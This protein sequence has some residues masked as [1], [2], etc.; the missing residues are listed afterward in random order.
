MQRT[1]YRINYENFLTTRP[2]NVKFKRCK[3][4]IPE[5]W[6]TKL[7]IEKASFSEILNIRNL[8]TKSNISNRIVSCFAYDSELETIWRNPFSKLKTLRQTLAVLTP[9]FSVTPSM[10]KAQIINS[11]F[12]N[13]WMG[14]FYQQYSIDVIPTVSWAEPW[15][16][17]ICF[18]GLVQG[19]P[20]AV[21]TIGVED[22]KMF[23]SGYNYLIKKKKPK[24]VI[25]FGKMIN[26]MKGNLICFDYEEAFM[27]NKNY[28]QLSFID[29]SRLQRIE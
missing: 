17:S 24:Y 21:S 28:E 23:L 18:Q 25:C 2:L 4:G 6:K 9:D 19:N 22:K 14:C 8:S 3:Y 13:R 1:D 15:T 7:T 29:V 16:Y 5:L 20:I 11:T 26:G 10:T 12:K 27:P